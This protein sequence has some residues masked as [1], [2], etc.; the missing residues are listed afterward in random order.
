MGHSIL[1]EIRHV[2]LE[3]VQTLL[4]RP[5]MPVT[6]IADFCGFRTHLALHRFFVAAT[7]LTMSEWRRKHFG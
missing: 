1:D 6:A 5:E 3:K 4:A 7:G 2:R